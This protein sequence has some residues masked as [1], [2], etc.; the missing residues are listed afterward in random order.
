[1]R[2]TFYVHIAADSFLR[3]ARQ[4]AALAL[5]G[6][7][8][9][10]HTIFHPCRNRRSFEPGLDLGRYS[11]H[12]W[13]KE[14]EIANWILSQV[15][16]RQDRT[17]GNTCWDNWIGPRG[18]TTCLEA[19]ARDYFVAARGGIRSDV[20]KLGAINFYNLGTRCAD[21]LKLHEI[22]SL[23]NEAIS[24]GGWLILTFHGVGRGTHDL[25]VEEEVHHALMGWLQTIKER[26]WVAPIRDVVA[27]IRSNT[28]SRI[29]PDI[30]PPP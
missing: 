13:R 17:F 21:G 24:V 25:F 10:N 19:L 7:E 26:I 23:I 6:H 14:V 11:E 1:M 15:D 20:M 9:G 18:A 4:W 3:S 27:H 22:Q 5:K 8:L 12:R 28:K 16:K 2:G 29:V 30:E